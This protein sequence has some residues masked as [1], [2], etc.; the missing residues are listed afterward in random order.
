MR[1]S[2]FVRHV[3]V[4]LSLV[5]LTGCFQPKGKSA[6]ELDRLQKVDAS[7][8]SWTADSI[9]GSSKISKV[10]TTFKT[11]EAKLYN[12][13]VCVADRRT[14][15]SLAGHEFR[16]H[17]E[18]SG[19]S[20]TVKADA[21]GCLNWSEEIRF[22]FFADAKYLPLA[23]TAAPVRGH[24]GE[25]EF[26]F[27]INP[28]AEGAD[29]VI[30]LSRESVL[31]EQ[32]ASATDVRALLTRSSLSKP[33]E[34]DEL[35]VEIQRPTTGEAVMRLQMVPTVW[36]KDVEGKST[37]HKITE[38]RFRVDARIVA[39]GP[40]SSESELERLVI[41]NV[42]VSNGRLL[43]SH[44][45]KV[46]G[47]PVEGRV[48]IR[49][50]LQPI[51][52][53]LA[54]GG[55]NGSF[56]LGGAD[57]MNGS[58]SLNLRRDAPNA[59]S[60]SL[61]IADSSPA[62]ALRP[63]SSGARTGAEGDSGL[64]SPRLLP[65][66]TFE[67]SRLTG[68]HERFISETAS[69]RK[70]E[71]S[72]ATCVSD[73]NDQNRR[74]RNRVFQV[75]SNAGLSLTIEADQD[76]CL[77]WRDQISHRYYQPEQLS[78]R[79]YSV[80]HAGRSATRTAVLY[81]WEELS[82]GYFVQDLEKVTEKVV[83]ETNARKLEPSR[84]IIP[85]FSFQTGETRQSVD[86]FLSLRVYRKFVLR[87]EPRVL[88]PSIRRG[89]NNIEPLRKGVY[90]LTVAMQR[91]H[92]EG[93]QPLEFISG[94]KKLVTVVDGRIITPVEFMFR[95]LRF[96]SMRNQFVVELAPVQSAL[97]V[98]G[99]V[100]KAM[101][102]NVD[103]DTLVN[104][105]D[106]L[107][108]RS[109]IGPIVPG[110]RAGGS[111]LRP[112]DSLEEAYCETIDCNQSNVADSR[113]RAERDPE[114]ERYYG[115]IRHLTGVSAGQLLAR[116]RELNSAYHVRMNKMA[117]LSEF[118]RAHNVEYVPLYNEDSI[119]QSDPTI[120]SL[121]RVLKI[122]GA[123]GTWLNGLAKP[124][125][126]QT[127]TSRFNNVAISRETVS[128]WLDGYPLSQ[129]E[130]ARLCAW[131]MRDF[132]P[133]LAPNRKLFA[134]EQQA[135][136]FSWRCTQAFQSG[137]PGIA[138]FFKK[139]RVEAFS[140]ER[141]LRVFEVLRSEFP[142]GWKHDY[143]VSSSLTLAATESRSRTN[144]VSAS[145]TGLL[146]MVPSR[147]FTS[148]IS[149]LNW[150]VSLNHSHD[151][152]IESY[153]SAGSLLLLQVEVTEGRLNIGRH[154]KC[155][156]IRLN[157][158]LLADV[159]SGDFAVDLSP[160]TRSEL[161]T[162]GLF[163]CKGIVE[164]APIAAIERYYYAS[165]PDYESLQNDGQ[166]GR[167]RPWMMALRGRGDFERFIRDTEARP[168]NGAA[169]VSEQVDSGTAP[170]DRINEAFRK[171]LPSYPGFYTWWP[172]ENLSSI[173]TSPRQSHGKIQRR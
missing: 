99:P 66:A 95:D 81:P 35:G 70:I 67:I 142:N 172:G 157:P 165:Q 60:S 22:E 68:R 4:G 64:G 104:Q 3:L 109:F 130:S 168:V 116:S 57:A 106:G 122:P 24:S 171:T 119:T 7:N 56:R 84:L 40:N 129:L 43:A 152:A 148:L 89:E 114:L 15:D 107:A 144:S 118:A 160:Q 103:L 133:A 143:Q 127:R 78:L 132:L 13:S 9:S 123:S 91:D 17:S 38:G 45:L 6:E 23:F 115:G 138:G 48:D 92:R 131:W 47:R 50:I 29:E 134:S 88:R 141:K 86:E 5:S 28:W 137:R 146:A 93:D 170:I 14:Q 162:R 82:F 73:P 112:T 37:A 8:A 147:I 169:G 108:A 25:R 85:D 62:L 102:P 173:E 27:A 163:V 161:L 52:G 44:G 135:R 75:T 59:A 113:T 153:T 139:D 72:V 10:H 83:T 125:P 1:T 11:P 128:R 61:A 126:L 41:Q 74:Q 51:D 79:Q 77:E 145:P 46:T 149:G 36:R 71:F 26:K 98:Q 42:E 21:Q 34:I 124:L 20:Q 121:N 159:R 39:V 32:L 154:E 18:G 96:L 94:V 55:F 30:D 136:K 69:E 101:D 76:G 12:F 16:I 166:E 167:N 58:K 65:A 120:G 2:S 53:P 54:L 117:R 90:L 110:Q 80:S 31:L 155:G 19:K 140:I 111:A 49:L 158:E 87:L 156:V 97:I 164:N 100:P 63:G 151:K 105:D 33:I 150:S